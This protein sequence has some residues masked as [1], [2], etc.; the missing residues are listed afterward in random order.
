MLSDD[1]TIFDRLTAQVLKLFIAF[2]VNFTAVVSP[3]RELRKQKA[4]AEARP[5]FYSTKS[6]ETTT[7]AEN[8]KLTHR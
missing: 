1:G 6:G 2:K 5:S 7:E 4:G 8:L 3:E